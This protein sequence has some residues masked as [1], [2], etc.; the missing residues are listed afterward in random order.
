MK[1]LNFSI[2]VTSGYMI[3]IYFQTFSKSVLNE[4]RDEHQCETSICVLQGITG[5]G[6]E[7]YQN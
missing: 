2:E 4:H 6:S 5:M 7:V 3:S 1:K